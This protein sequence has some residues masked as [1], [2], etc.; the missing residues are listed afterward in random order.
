MLPHL[1]RPFSAS[2]IIPLHT[3]DVK[4]FFLNFPQSTRAASVKFFPYLEV[5]S[6]L[7]L[8]NIFR[9]GLITFA[10]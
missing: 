1:V 10:A 3:S 2:E 6:D 9:S 8:V 4:R 5:R 7:Y